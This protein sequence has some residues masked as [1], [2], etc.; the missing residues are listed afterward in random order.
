MYH[1]TYVCE[2][3]TKTLANGLMT[4]AYA[5][6]GLLAGIGLDDIEQQ[7]GFARNARARGEDD[8]VE[9]LQLAHFEL[10]IAVDGN[11]GTEFLD[12]MTQVI[13]KRV[14]IIYDY[15]FHYRRLIS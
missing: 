4:K 2:L 1:L 11:L 10:I 9:L 13:R 7:S 15:Y 5:K 8:L 12:Q 3:A 6:D 14:V